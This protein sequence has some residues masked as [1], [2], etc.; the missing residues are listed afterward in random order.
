MDREKISV[1][2]LTK[3]EQANI[4]EC[5]ACVK[6]WADEIIV[7]DDGS[8]DNTVSLAKEYTDKVLEREMDIEGRQR[9][10]AYSRAANEWVLS[11]D[12]DERVTQELKNEIDE[13]LSKVTVYNGFTIPR[14]NFIGRQ[15]IRYS[16]WYP[17]PQL[18]LFRKDK[19]KYE[20]VSVH[21][22]AFMDNPCGHLKADLIH[23]SYK[24]IEDFIQKLNRQTSLEAEKWISTGRKMSFGVALWRTVDRFFR[25][26]IGKKGYRDGFIGVMIAYFDS[27]YQILSYAKYRQMKI[28]KEEKQR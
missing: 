13:V 24:D 14:R 1:V 23:Y 6:D 3:N 27:L 16:G 9:N 21:P 11:L 17:S 25:R 7:V 26:F 19:F 20:E 28:E 18:K 8:E 15:W 5:L 12:A 2:V 22:R 10:W 4:R